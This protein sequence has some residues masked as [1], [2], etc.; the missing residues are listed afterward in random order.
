MAEQLLRLRH[1]VDDR[2]VVDAEAPRRGAVVGP[3]AEERLQRGEQAAALVV[4]DRQR[5]EVGAH[6][7]P[8]GLDVAGAQRGQLDG[9]VA[10]HA[11]LRALG[12][13]G[14]PRGLQRLAV[15]GAEAGQAAGGPADPGAHRAADRAG[16]LD[17]GADRDPDPRGPAVDEHRERPA[18]AAGVRQAARRALEQRVGHLIAGCRLE[19]RREMPAGEV[20]AEPPARAREVVRVGV[21]DA[22]DERGLRDRGLLSQAPR[23]V[24]VLDGGLVGEQVGPPEQVP[25]PRC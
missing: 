8:A 20:V 9:G 7:A 25:R 3:L 15:A 22:A 23:L 1:A 5:A 18:G 16:S 13:L 14:D 4:G 11:A 24:D 19:D 21:Q 6:E 17:V 10:G 2:V 12:E